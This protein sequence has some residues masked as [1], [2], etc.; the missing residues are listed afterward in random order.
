MAFVAFKFSEKGYNV[1]VPDLRGH[2]KSNGKNIN[3]GWLDRLDILKWIDII[4]KIN[5]EANIILVGG[6]MGASVV[7]MTSGEELP[8]NVKGIIADCGYTSVCSEFKVMLHSAL[9]LP[10]FPIITFANR[11]AKKKV[12]FTLKQ[13]SAVKQLTKN[14]VP[15]LFIHGTGEK[16][17]PHQMLYE[18]ME[19]TK[20]IKESLLIEHAPHLSSFIYEPNYYFE[21]IFEFIKRYCSGEEENNG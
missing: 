5:I 18:N 10:A 3:M 7:M 21:T 2:G 15:C 20:G 4:L 6:S 16:F 13:A 8:K 11:L 19:A 9:K 14:T 12:G 1:L 17:V